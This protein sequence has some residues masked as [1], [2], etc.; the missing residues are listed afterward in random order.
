MS[1]LECLLMAC[2]YAALGVPLLI[3]SLNTPEAE[4][5]TKLKE[6]GLKKILAYPTNAVIVSKVLPLQQIVCR[7]EELGKEVGGV[8]RCAENSFSNLITQDKQCI[9]NCMKNCDPAEP[10]CLVNCV[11]SCTKSVVQPVAQQDVLNFETCVK[12][13]PLDSSKCKSI[14]SQKSDSKHPWGTH[15]LSQEFNALR[16]VS[17]VVSILLLV[18]SFVKLVEMFVTK[19]SKKVRSKKSRK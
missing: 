19:S 14:L 10:G 12:N 18:G 3:T 5:L 16:M 9:F 1:K 15:D 13:I 7:G 11:K 6:D 4:D 17:L 2:V 8:I